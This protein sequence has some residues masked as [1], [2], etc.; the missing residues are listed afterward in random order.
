[1]HAHLATGCKTYT[2]HSAAANS[3]SGYSHFDIIL[4]TTISTLFLL[5]CFTEEMARALLLPSYFHC[6]FI[7]CGSSEQH[8]ASPSGLEWW[9]RHP[10]T[11]HTDQEWLIG[12]MQS[13][14]VFMPPFN[15]QFRWLTLS[16]FFRFSSSRLR[17]FLSSAKSSIVA[18][19]SFVAVSSCLSRSSSW[20][21]NM[22]L[23]HV[24][25]EF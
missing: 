25:K 23:P 8:W 2:W 1:M 16:F 24:T 17:Q 4:A 10:A 15:A 6:S 3:C 11:D 21:Q 12:E 7:S 9:N 18:S 22:K 20:K 19:C 5:P 13:R 14:L